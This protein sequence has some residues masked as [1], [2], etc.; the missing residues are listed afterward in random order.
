MGG[1]RSTAKSLKECKVLFYSKVCSP[2]YCCA[3]LLDHRLIKRTNLFWSSLIYSDCCSCVSG[4][5]GDGGFRSLFEK[6]DRFCDLVPCCR[7]TKTSEM[8]WWRGA[9]KI[10]GYNKHLLTLLKFSTLMYTAYLNWSLTSACF[11]RL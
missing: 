5:E 10:C 1:S 6:S 7:Y 11:T 2:P 3:V 9:T 4:N 8:M